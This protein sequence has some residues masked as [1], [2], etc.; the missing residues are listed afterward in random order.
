[1]Q[2]ARSGRGEEEDCV[3]GNR[4]LHI[5]P[6]RDEDWKINEDGYEDG[7]EQIRKQ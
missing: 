6:C 5:V 1:M 7:Y 2:L 3:C 4:C